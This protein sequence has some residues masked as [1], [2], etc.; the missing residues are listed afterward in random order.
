MALPQECRR[1][2]R[3]GTASRREALTGPHHQG[4][5]ASFAPE[6]L[7][8]QELPLLLGG[9]YLSQCQCMSYD[10]QVACTDGSS[11]IGRLALSPRRRRLTPLAGIAIFGTLSVQA[12]QERTTPRSEQH[13]F[14]AQRR[15]SF[16][17]T[18]V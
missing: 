15:A 3:S 6:I 9:N 4:S 16:T 12:L 11:A 7:D 17:Q 10:E 1:F 13:R 5:A 18:R 8:P 14:H 2:L